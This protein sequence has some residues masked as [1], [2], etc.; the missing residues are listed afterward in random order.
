VR[1]DDTRTVGE[2]LAEMLA[3]LGLGVG[4]VVGLWVLGVLI[5]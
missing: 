3:V 2:V 5:Q 4:I 1:H